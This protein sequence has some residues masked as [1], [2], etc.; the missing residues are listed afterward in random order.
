METI[1]AKAQSV[2]SSESYRRINCKFE[3]DIVDC[4]VQDL[5]TDGK[6]WETEINIEGKKSDRSKKEHRI[7]LCLFENE[8]IKSTIE[9]KVLEQYSN[10]CNGHFFPYIFYGNSPP[11]I[12]LCDGCKENEIANLNCFGS[13]DG[14]ALNHKEEGQLF[15]DIIKTLFFEDSETFP[16]ENTFNKYILFY[17][18]T[19]D[20][21]HLV[22][23]FGHVKKQL[24][25]ITNH[26]SKVSNKLNVYRITTDGNP[27]K[28]RH[29]A[30]SFSGLYKTIGEK[31]IGCCCKDKEYLNKEKRNIS[32]AIMKFEPAYEYAFNLEK[33]E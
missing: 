6:V 13:V 8:K 26:F 21:N 24:G 11:K 32:L 20:E 15:K 29:R 3:D 30:L 10:K 27:I 16:N 33:C 9:V 19:K 31:S 12:T 7:D 4:L 22:H 23:D 1:F 28:A 17:I 25:S 14:N 2:F 5:A 18:L